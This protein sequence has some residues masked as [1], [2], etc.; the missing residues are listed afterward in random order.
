MPLANKNLD[1]SDWK[2]LW[3][4]KIDYFEYQLSQFGNKH[5]LIRESF[6]YYTGYVEMAISLLNDLP[7]KNN[8]LVLTHK[9]IR[10]NSTL[11][12]LYDPFNF[13]IDHKV[14]DAAEYFK[15]KIFELREYS[16]ALPFLSP[17]LNQ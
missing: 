12:D 7:K 10:G 13:V 2:R 8:N 11:Y 6:A 9:R 17:I 3:E 16:L 15:S 1:C 14:R 5:P 4:E